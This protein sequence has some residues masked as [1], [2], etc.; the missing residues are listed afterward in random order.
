LRSALVLPPTPGA[1]LPARACELPLKQFSDDEP[2]LLERLSVP[3][4]V[5]DRYI[6]PACDL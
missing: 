6:P 2:E 5:L 4:N 1:R 3:A